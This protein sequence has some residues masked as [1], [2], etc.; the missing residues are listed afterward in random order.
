MGH[1]IVYRRGDPCPQAL[2]CTALYYA[3]AHGKLLIKPK[4]PV[5]VEHCTGIIYQIRC[6]DCSWTYMYIGQLGHTIL[7]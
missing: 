5:P 3:V 1:Y 2:E 4:D 7:D 6:K